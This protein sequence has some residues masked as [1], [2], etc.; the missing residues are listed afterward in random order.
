M[1]EKEDVQKVSISTKVFS[2]PPEG[3]RDELTFFIS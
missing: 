3:F 1:I 2:T